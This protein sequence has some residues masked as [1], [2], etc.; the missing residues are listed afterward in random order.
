MWGRQS[1]GFGLMTSPSGKHPDKREQPPVWENSRD[2]SRPKSSS[3][4]PQ[5]YPSSEVQAKVLSHHKKAGVNSRAASIGHWR[6]LKSS[7]RC[8]IGPES[9]PCSQE[10]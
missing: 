7:N 5:P 3:L 2:V 10:S 6:V 9:S 1:S 8:L 4:N